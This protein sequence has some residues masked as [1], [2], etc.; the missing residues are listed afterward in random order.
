MFGRIYV[1]IYSAEYK[2]LERVSYILERRL[3]NVTY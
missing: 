2:K 1:C 3:F